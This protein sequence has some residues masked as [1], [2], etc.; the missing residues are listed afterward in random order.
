[1]QPTPHLTRADVLRVLAREFPGGDAAALLAVLD[2]YGGESWHRERERVQ[3]AI[4]KLAGGDGERLRHY[5]KNAQEDYR[6]VL[7]WAEY[8]GYVREVPGPGAPPPEEA[9]RIIA[10]DWAQY[11]AW[12]RR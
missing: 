10:A 12:L 8:P 2:E 4:L 11:Q 1:M 7:A 9:Q 3:M 6:D 5:V